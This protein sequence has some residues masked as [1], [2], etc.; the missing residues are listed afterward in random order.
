MTSHALPAEPT[1]SAGLPPVVTRGKFIECHECGLRQ[2]LVAL[3]VGEKAKCPRCGATLRR[4][5]TAP[6]ERAIALCFAGLAL[7]AVANFLPF[8]TMSIEGRDQQ[9]DLVTGVLQLWALGDWP[10]AL[11]VL[12][13]TV[14]APLFK[15]V[16]LL[17]VLLA[18][19]LRRPP[20]YLPRLYR[21]VAK[22]HPWSMIE[23]Y[24]LGV[25][26]AY[27][28]LVDLA[29]IAV[30]PALFAL[31]ALMVLMVALSAVHDP[32]DVWEAMVAK[33]VSRARPAR[34]G[35]AAILCEDCGLLA[36]APHDGDGHH[37]HCPRCGAPLHHR[38]PEAMARAWALVIAAA[39]LYIPANL[40]P[41]MVVTSLGS[42]ESDT[43][44][45]GVIY[46]ATSGMLPI[47]ILVF[48]ASITV[49]LLKL[50]G[51]VYLMIGTMRRSRLRLR[52]RALMYRIIEAVG[53]WSMIDIF[54]VSIL[55]AL[56]RLG[57]LASIAPGPGAT[58]FAAVVVLTMFAAG[59]FDPRLM[60]DAAGENDE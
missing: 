15:L 34:P 53:R 28:K 19:Q 36:P 13:T 49:P 10:L 18:L 60:W 40:F 52:D 3:A 23:V 54:M 50:L 24:M 25:F 17:W 8:I 2:H 9:A 51:L 46:L 14:A 42:S 12:L 35:Q 45:S 48:F 44:M 55:V 43:I 39:I 16:S 31:A 21:W 47:A 37:G 32:E 7:M 26:V 20:R 1:V 59:A 6:L 29:T 22:L 30:G 5:L 41:V 27:V 57:A 33:R 11:V 58:A 56:V 38:K 4:G